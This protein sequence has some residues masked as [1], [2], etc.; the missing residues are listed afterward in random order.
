MS[1]YIRYI[2]ST[3]HIKFYLPIL[4]GW[5]FVCCLLVSGCRRDELCFFH[6]DG[7]NLV[8]EID[9]KTLA[10]VTPNAA[11]IMIYNAD[12]GSFFREEILTTNRNRHILRNMPMG[13]Y[14]MVVFNETRG[15]SHFDLT[16][17][18]KGHTAWQDFMAYVLQDEV[19]GRYAG[20]GF[21]TSGPATRAIYTNPDTLAVERLQGYE[22][23]PNMID[24]VH[25][26]PEPINHGKEYPISDTIRFVPQR[27]IS[28]ANVVLKGENLESIKSYSCY[29]SGM[30]ES[31]KLG[32]SEY[33]MS[34]V[35]YP[36]VFKSVN[37]KYAS[38]NQGDV[39]SLS[40]SFSVMGLQGDISPED[41]TK[42]EGYVVDLRMVLM[43]DELQLERF[44]LVKDKCMTRS[45]KFVNGLPHDGIDIE[46]KV[47]LPYIPAVGGGIV[48][49]IED[50]NDQTV[51]LETT[52]LKFHPNQGSGTIT[53]IQRS[54]NT[55]IPLPECSFNPPTEPK[56]WT[57]K[58]KEWNTAN[59]GTG[60]SYQPGDLFKMP[61]GGALLYAIWDPIKPEKKEEK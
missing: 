47:N 39:S 31:Y 43:N 13:R 55:Q 36:V 32:P 37:R 51:H 7:A 20:L 19:G 8:V 46:L 21:V 11:T 26:D 14:D 57:F 49:D 9:W 38:G 35:V 27:I 29:L 12:D 41:Y 1:N 59:D 6:P 45:H 61:K 4:A 10:E 28:V 50:W 3:G 30:S 48:T 2:R 52:V 22:V 44:D 17:G 18:Y 16:I 40:T 23:T 34:P 42:E 58:F 25:I 15:G 5:M 24:I 33:S 53:P 56:D 54:I 60:K